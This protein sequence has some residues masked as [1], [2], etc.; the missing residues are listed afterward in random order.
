MLKS[1]LHNY[2]QCT[3]KNPKVFEHNL[4][5]TRISLANLYKGLKKFTESESLY[6]ISLQTYELLYKLYPA[7]YTRYLA[8]T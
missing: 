4:A 8:S 7:V 3:E 2:E 6:K 5:Q 1:A